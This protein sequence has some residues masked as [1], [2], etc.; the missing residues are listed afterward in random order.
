[1]SISP[2]PLRT[3]FRPPT[4][5]V[6]FLVLDIVIDSAFNGLHGLFT[7]VRFTSVSPMN[8]CGLPPLNGMRLKLSSVGCSLSCG[9]GTVSFG[10]ARQR[11]G[12]GL[13]EMIVY[14]PKGNWPA[15]WPDENWPDGNW[16]ELPIEFC[17][18]GVDG[19]KLQHDKESTPL[20]G[21]VALE[22]LLL[23]EVD[24]IFT[25][26]N[27]GLK[28][29]STKLRALL[30]ALGSGILEVKAYL[31]GVDAPAIF[32]FR[33][34][35]IKIVGSIADVSSLNVGKSGHMVHTD[36]CITTMT[37]GIVFAFHA[38][39]VGA[40]FALEEMASW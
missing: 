6:S 16:E 36:A 31:N 12:F 35:V 9:V 22:T 34:L 29:R 21:Q 19:T 40:L 24:S 13:L 3:N 8:V 11:Q 20:C 33:S 10:C 32:S 15:N 39:V 1:M 27:L 5:C 7:Y 28:I 17:E 38:R 23:T 2:P 37:S 26:A 14:M 4:N 18:D 30:Q 25:A